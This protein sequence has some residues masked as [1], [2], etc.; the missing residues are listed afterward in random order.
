MEQPAAQLFARQVQ[1]QAH[2]VAGAF[3]MNFGRCFDIQQTLG[4]QFVQPL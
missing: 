4:V 2:Q 1:I 3:Q